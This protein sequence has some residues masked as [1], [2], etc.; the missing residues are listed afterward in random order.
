M[1]ENLEMETEKEAETYATIMERYFKDHPD[2]FQN[3]TSKFIYLEGVL[4]GFLLEVQRIA[5]PEKTTNESFWGALHD[6]RMDQRI[7]M[8]LFPKIV[9][10]FKQLGKSYSGLVKEVSTYMQQ[11]GTK[12]TLTTIEMSWYFVHGLSSY[13]NFRKPKPTE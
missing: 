2:F 6:L 5:N 12:W 4:A 10:K 1:E 3:D 7:L 8:E 9:A 11:A 13:A